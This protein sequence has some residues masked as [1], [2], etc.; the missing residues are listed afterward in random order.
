MNKI[1]VLPTSFNGIQFLDARAFDVPINVLDIARAKH[2][3]GWTPTVNLYD[4]LLKM[5][6][7]ITK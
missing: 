1:N 6:N 7:W 4:G 5:K 3:L 2:E